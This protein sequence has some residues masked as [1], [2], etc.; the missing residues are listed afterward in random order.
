MFLKFNTNQKLKESDGNYLFAHFSLPAIATCPNAGKCKVGCYATQGNYRYPS[1]QKSYAANLKLT[2][3]L[4]LFSAT[5][6]GE[7]EK[8]DAKARKAGKYLAVRIHTSGDFYSKDYYS[9]WVDLAFRFPMVKFY[10]YTKMVSQARTRVLP[11]NF[12]LIFSEGG[13]QDGQIGSNDRHSRVFPSLEALTAAGYDDASEDDSVA[14]LSRTGKI[15]LIYHGVA[16]RAW[17][18]DRNVRESQVPLRLVD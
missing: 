16:K 10:A 4:K 5:L 6:V 11:F 17:S 2:Q 15:G 18:T 9:A 3:N 1:V 8:L 12:C 7:L 14:F 13:L